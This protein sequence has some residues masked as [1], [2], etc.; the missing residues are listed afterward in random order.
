M[1]IKKINILKL[2]EY[3]IMRFE[4][5]GIPLTNLKLQKLL[6]YIQAWHTVF[7]DRH[8]LFEDKP[9]AWANGP[10]YK[11]VY[12][13]YKNGSNNLVLGG[14]DEEKLTQSLEGL[15]LN[16]EQRKFLEAVI[17]KYGYLTAEQLVYLTHNEQPW[18]KAREG[19]DIFD[20]SDKKIEIDTMYEYYSK[21]VKQKV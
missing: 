15:E 11:K 8:P 16:T 19:L 20:K 13:A 3:L 4:F 2:A 12:Q 5:E 21:R 14:I 6:Y 7:F 10:V 17:N 9:E 1:E 18:K